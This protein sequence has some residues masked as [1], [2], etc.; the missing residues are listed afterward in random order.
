MAQVRRRFF[1][2]SYGTGTV[3]LSPEANSETLP[4]SADILQVL[5]TLTNATPDRAFWGA[6][7]DCA[8][9]LLTIDRIS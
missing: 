2:V 1:G 5:F 7:S 3:T 4:Q 6:A 9:F 8:K